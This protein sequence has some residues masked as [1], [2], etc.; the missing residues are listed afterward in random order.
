MKK[1]RKSEE[2]NRAR[3]LVYRL[4]FQLKLEFRVKFI[5]LVAKQGFAVT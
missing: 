5:V 2:L 1:R 3:I 4:D